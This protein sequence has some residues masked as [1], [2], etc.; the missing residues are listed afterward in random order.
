MCSI[1][2]AIGPPTIEKCSLSTTI[3][4][5]DTT[6]TYSLSFYYRPDIISPLYP[7]QTIYVTAYLDNEALVTIPLTPESEAQHYIQVKV[8]RI[9]PQSSSPLLKFELSL[10]DLVESRNA[11][12][13]IFL[14]TVSLTSEAIP[15]AVCAPAPPA[16]TDA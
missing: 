4:G 1:L 9:R 3:Y 6:S 10:P 5:L 16:P 13:F 11:P 14:D 7:S 12:V 8:E 2:H 15:I